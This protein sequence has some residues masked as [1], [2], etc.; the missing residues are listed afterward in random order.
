M[1]EEYSE[2]RVVDVGE[3]F[4]IVGAGVAAVS[5]AVVFSSVG[6]AGAVSTTSLMVSVMMKFPFRKT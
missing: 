5:A 4:V 1:C 2:R 3:R 6:R